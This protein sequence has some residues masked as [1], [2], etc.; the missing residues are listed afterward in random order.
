MKISTDTVI[1]GAG[2]SGMS[3][4]FHLRNQDYLILEKESEAGG[5][6]RTIER[7]GFLFDYGIHV[8]FS[9]DQY[10]KDFVAMLLG[11]N[12]IAQERN[13][14]CFSHGLL[15]KYPFQLNLYG[16]SPEIIA[17][18]L[19]GM[20]GKTRHP[21]LHTFNFRDWLKN[22][23]GQGIAEHFL[24]P[25]NEKNWSHDLEQMDFKWAN[26]R[27]PAPEF[28]DVVRGALFP[29]GPNVGPATDFWY[30]KTDGVGA[31]SKALAEKVNV[32]YDSEVV[33]INPNEKIVILDNGTEI[34]Y[35]K[36]V[37]TIPLP[38]L[39]SAL[40][41]DATDEMRL[42]AASLVSNVVTTINVGLKSPTITHAHWIYFSEKI[43]PFHRVSFPSNFSSNMAPPGRSSVQ[44]EISSLE[45][46]N[47]TEQITLMF[48]S[49]SQ[50]SDLG[51][52]SYVNQDDIATYDIQ[53]INPAY[54]IYKLGY[55]EHVGLLR[56]ELAKRDI[57]TCG[58]FGSWQY[59]NID[60][61]LLR[62]K[63]VAER[64]NQ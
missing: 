19:I 38:H 11:D 25:Y 15:R 30:P 21:G 12:F 56:S 9:K 50:L 48:N 27:V 1:L 26:E 41:P 55:Q 4:A 64:I 24:V 63:E 54:V 60:E 53:T 20:A 22:T 43:F 33:A 59:I 46:F 35:Q 31:L 28:N 29:P 61:S 34:S 45:P 2:F 40:F 14:F 32:R 42:A 51:L 57:Y 8:L 44:M 36:I 39:I 52:I 18:C 3:T 13:S 17:D 10:V 37:S 7:G 58:R 49:L 5:L 16:L 62:G 23:F 6:A 47:K